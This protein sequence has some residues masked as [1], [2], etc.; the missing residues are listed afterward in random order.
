[1]RIGSLFSGI[2]GLEL[3]LELSGLGETV[4]QVE[5][6]AYC[7]AVL[8]R[9]WPN[10]ERFGDVR[11]V[12]AHCLPEADLICG[13]FPCQDVS[14]AGLRAGLSGARSGLWTEFSRIVREIGPQWVVV[15]NVA[16]GA[17]LWVDAVTAD[18]AQLGFG[19]LQVPL[20]AADC[21]AP[22]RRSRVF[23]VGV[24]PSDNHGEPG[25]SGLGL[26]PEPASMERRLEALCERVP[27]W[28][29]QGARVP[30][31][32]RVGH[33]VSRRVDSPAR[34][35]RALGNAVVPAQAEVIGHVVRILAGGGS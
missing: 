4:W 22:H 34:R 20:D 12:G 15:E 29:A 2:G 3:G 9:H 16:S 14:R 28:C 10:A 21:G 32:R 25:A 27:Q 11:T 6:D 26:Q 33:G 5:S 13:G 7:R 19:I 30:D 18:L 35:L 31:L 23:L 24:R 17:G 1:M 8:E